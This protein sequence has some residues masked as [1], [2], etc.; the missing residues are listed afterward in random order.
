MKPPAA[1]F[2]MILLLAGGCFSV[3]PDAAPSGTAAEEEAFGL[4]RA[5]LAA[6][7]N[8]LEIHTVE[9]LQE[10]A[11]E[12][13][14]NQLLL[15][16]PEAVAEARAGRIPD[17]PEHDSRLTFLDAAIAYCHLLAPGEDA[18]LAERRKPR[19]EELLDCAVALLWCKLAAVTA[20]IDTIGPTPERNQRAEELKMEL[21]L[22]TGLSA[23][24]LARFDFSSLACP[25][26]LSEELI[27]LQ[28]RAVRQRSESRGAR[29]GAGLWRRCE[30]FFGHDRAMP[31]LLAEG[32]L[33]LPRRISERSIADPGFRAE[34][35]ARLASALGV[36][37]EIDLLYGH[38]TRAYEVWRLAKLKQELRPEGEEEFLAELSARLSW[39]IAHYRMTA[40]LGRPDP[41]PPE[42][43]EE[44]PDS[45]LADRLFSLLGE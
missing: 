38:L 1:A 7:A 25:E 2:S 22:Y 34:E 36:A 26:P 4:R 29:F 15:R 42:P 43:E 17:N 35:T 23:G 6:R 33:R 45:E 32:L 44:E 9:S 41:T 18:D 27:A 14:D 37:A 3:A 30:R 28:K 13:V 8:F 40:D 10:L 12:H 21:R 31:F 19:S 16:L 24:E 11:G 20:E 39:R 5:Q